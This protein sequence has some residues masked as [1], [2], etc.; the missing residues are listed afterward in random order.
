MGMIV[1]PSQSGQKGSEILSQP[2]KA[3]YWWGLPFIPAM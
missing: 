2:I 3:G 1:F